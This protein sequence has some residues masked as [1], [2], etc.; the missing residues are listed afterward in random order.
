MWLLYFLLELLSLFFKSLYSI[1]SATSISS[2][3]LS[4]FSIIVFYYVILFYSLWKKLGYFL[5]VE[6]FLVEDFED[7]PILL[8]LKFKSILLPNTINSSSFDY[9]YYFSNLLTR[10]PICLNTLSINC[11]ELFNF[12]SFYYNEVNLLYFL[13]FKSIGILYIYKLFKMLSL[14]YYSKLSYWTFSI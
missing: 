7:Y 8:L 6:R 4:S 9:Y 3:S 5:L 14:T 2:F 10:F 13:C 11:S 1:I 12:W